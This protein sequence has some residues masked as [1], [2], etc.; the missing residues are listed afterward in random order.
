MSN[1]FIDVHIFDGKLQNI[2]TPKYNYNIEQKKYM[3]NNLISILSKNIPNPEN[4]ISIIQTIINDLPNTS[5]I[6]PENNLDASDI[7]ADLI[8]YVDN[9]SFLILLAE[10]LSDI[11]NLGSCPSGRCTRLLQL[12]LSYK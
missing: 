6:Q 8:S 2:F 1:N 9:D 4:S 12:C 3:F 10:Q 7:L 11:N 5:N